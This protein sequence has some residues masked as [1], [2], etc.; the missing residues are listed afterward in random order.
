MPIVIEG[1]YSTPVASGAMES[2]STATLLKG[3]GL[4]GDRY[5]ARAGTYS[6]LTPE[7]GRQLTLISAEGVKQAMGQETSVGDL[8]RNVVLGGITAQELVDCVGSRIQL[9]NTATLLV[10]RN[11][12]P[13]MYN[14]RKNQIKGMME[15][16]WDAGGVNCE[17]LEG[18]TISVG[19]SLTIIKDSSENHVVT[20]GG[21]PSWFYVRPS[22]RTAEMVRE[23]IAGKRKTHE[24]LKESDP[25]G[26]ERA[27][28]SYESVGLCFW[29]K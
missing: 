29:P 12:V 16:L 5:A 4:K 17:V 20:D 9:G 10:H 2:H 27:Q 1:I 22:Q 14:E 6:V 19:D 26:V 28:K 24:R 7:P 21:K 11:C 25:E 18:G 8:R 15:A 13:C 3:I 23:G